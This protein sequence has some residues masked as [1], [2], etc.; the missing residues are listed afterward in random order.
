MK[1]QTQNKKGL[2]IVSY[3]DNQTEIRHFTDKQIALV[4]EY[5]KNEIDCFFE[6]TNT[7][8]NLQTKSQDFKG[9]MIKAGIFEHK[10]DARAKWEI[11]YF[12][13]VVNDNV[14]ITNTLEKHLVA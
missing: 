11:A 10:Y 5:L 14:K 13:D 9:K 6:A 7:W 1:N 8:V 12:C 4:R 2:C 3:D